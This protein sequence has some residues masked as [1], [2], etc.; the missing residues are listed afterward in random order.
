MGHLSRLWIGWVSS[1]SLAVAPVA[2]NPA[3]GAERIYIS[4]SV[5]ER[6]VPVEALEIY[7]KEGRITPELAA[8]TRYFNSRQLTWL[9]RGLRARVDLAPVTISSFLYTP[10]GEL[11]LQRLGQIIET[12]SRQP[13]FFAIRAALILAAAEP[14][15]LTALS[16]MRKFPTQGIR[17][18][19]SESLAIL[20]EIQKL[21][22]QTEAAVA[23]VRNQPL[24]ETSVGSGDITLASRAE[25][26][27]QLGNLGFSGPFAWQKETLQLTDPKRLGRDGTARTFPVDVYLPRLAELRPSP[28]IVF[29][30]GLGSDRQA[31]KYL[32][33]H[34]A[35]YGFVVAIPEHPGSSEQQLLA[36]L[37][38]QADDVAEP[39][40]FVDRPLDIKLLLDELTVR[41]QQDPTFQG[42]L[43]LQQV[44]V[45]GHS[46][47]GYTALVLAGAKINFE[48]LQRN[49]AMNLNNTLNISLILQCR[50]LVLPRRNYDLSD[51]RVKAVIAVNPIDSGVLGPSSLSQIRIPV[52]LV[53]GSADTVAPAL[54]EQIQPFT[55][56][57]APQKYLMLIEG[58]SHFSTIGEEALSSAI[59]R[60][61][62]EVV[63]PAPNLARSYLKAFS[64]SFF[65][66]HVAGRTDYAR[67]LTSAYA[68]A[69]TRAPLRLDLNQTLTAARLREALGENVAD[70]DV[71][72]PQSSPAET[73][74][75]Y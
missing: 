37:N 49:C 20:R 62:P 22:N 74:L 23:A 8:Y 10:T 11:L 66:T 52:M 40:E 39:R 55:W 31:F 7:A 58:A 46:F 72:T 29:S 73:P 69:I 63:G 12:P 19:L 38:G 48:R 59:F 27:S 65:K 61:P 42:R 15:G 28:V 14:E 50:A 1:L 33:E 17:V 30:H 56:L 68:T 67:Y 45:A 3:L 57:T 4:Y 60:I 47:G 51:P 21:V 18:D 6:S 32:G 35:S 2:W 26:N 34:L 16:I 41:S 70:A 75:S 54:Y 9:R 13:G 24:A 44:G 64:T 25:V 53:A 36:L 71:S 43:N 5:F